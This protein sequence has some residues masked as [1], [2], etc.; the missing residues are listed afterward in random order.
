MKF[1]SQCTHEM[2]KTTQEA[3]VAHIYV[4]WK[5]KCINIH[6]AISTRL[7]FRTTLVKFLASPVIKWYFLIN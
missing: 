2:D 3:N 1:L 7:H 6:I 4:A 5:P